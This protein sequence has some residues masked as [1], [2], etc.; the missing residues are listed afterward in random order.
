MARGWRWKYT[1]SWG[2]SHTEMGEQSSANERIKGL[3]EEYNGI[4]GAIGI[5]YNKSVSDGDNGIFKNVL[6]MLW[7]IYLCLCLQKTARKMMRLFFHTHCLLS[8][9]IQYYFRIIFYWFLWSLR[10]MSCIKTWNHDRKITLIL[11]YYRC[12]TELFTIKKVLVSS[13]SLEIS[14]ML[15]SHHLHW[16]RCRTE[17]NYKESDFGRPP[18]RSDKALQN[19]LPKYY[20]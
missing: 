19:S 3:S 17:Q 1:E 8:F 14:L 15:F 5:N 12:C 6:P 7:W 16:F 11:T 18:Q 13:K 2:E 9:K 20:A 10:Y 4:A